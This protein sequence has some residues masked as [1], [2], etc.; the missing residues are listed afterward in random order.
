MGHG[1]LQL[2]RVVAAAQRAHA[3]G[4]GVH[5]EVD[6][7]HPV[8]F[9]ADGGG[10]VFV[11]GVAEGVDDGPHGPDVAFG[12]LVGELGRLPGEGAAAPGGGAEA[13]HAEVGEDEGRVEAGVGLS[14]EH[15]S[16]FDVPVE[17][18]APLGRRG[19]AVLVD[20]V[21]EQ[22]Q[23]VGEVVERLPDEGFGD[24]RAAGVEGVDEPLKIAAGVVFEV[25]FG[26]GAEFEA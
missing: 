24:V 26:C 20:A 3:A 13:G 22:H 21:V 4:A 10:A 6:G 25:D 16:G 17:D 19:G 18:P 23:G 11:G 2:D 9:F 1:A 5:D 12:A 8:G 15:V 14:E 7:F